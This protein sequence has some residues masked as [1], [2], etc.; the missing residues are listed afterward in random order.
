MPQ[1]DDGRT[2]FSLD[3]GSI[4]E[5]GSGYDSD[6]EGTPTNEDGTG[7][8]HV[9][10]PA[11]AITN[12]VYSDDGIYYCL[13]AIATVQPYV[14][15]PDDDYDV[16][17]GDGVVKVVGG[18]GGNAVNLKPAADL[19]GKCLT[20]KKGDTG[21]PVT[22]TPDGSDKIDGASTYALATQHDCV[23]L[24]SDGTGWMVTA[25]IVRAP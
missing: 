13:G 25:E 24:V 10:V 2:F 3:Q 16:L 5:I 17:P 12:V 19:T 21:D 7:F 18:T 14:A 4:N 8:L 6:G 23:T 22:I 11:G 9:E 1:Q 20:F 15:P